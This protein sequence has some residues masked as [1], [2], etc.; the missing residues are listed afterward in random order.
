[1]RPTVSV[2]PTSDGEFADSPILIVD[3]Q[4]ENLRFLEDVLGE[5]GFIN[6]QTT[7][8]A[9]RAVT[10]WSEFQPDL[11]ILDLH[12]PE[13]N[14]IAVMEALR[15][16]LAEDEYLPFLILTS[17]VSIDAKERSFAAGAADFLIKPCNPID[18]V[19]RVRALLRTRAMFKRIVRRKKDDRR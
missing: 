10:I 5:A 11:I 15:A 3:D 8:N 16:C 19:L 1:M 18:I 13:M 7:T 6:C 9:S 17:D 12:M 4:V 14:G 2:K